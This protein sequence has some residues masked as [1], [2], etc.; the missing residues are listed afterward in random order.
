MFNTTSPFVKSCSVN[1]IKYCF[2]V[3]T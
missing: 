2:F 1:Y 3:C